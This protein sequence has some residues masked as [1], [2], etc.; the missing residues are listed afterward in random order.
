[1]LPDPV[2]ALFP[3]SDFTWLTFVIIYAGVLGGIGYL[4]RHPRHLL[5]AVQTYLLMIL[6]RIIGMSLMPLDPP[7]GMIALKDPFVEFFGSGTTLTR[8]LFF[9]G[10]TATVFIVALAAPGRPAKIVFLVCTALVAACVLLQHVHYAIDVFA[11]PFFAYGCYR[12]ALLVQRKL[13]REA[14]PRGS[15]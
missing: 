2:L 13:E 4:V 8:D 15:S 7:P 9:S 3:A 10:H 11:A 1:M 12:A 6:A 14:A 5:L